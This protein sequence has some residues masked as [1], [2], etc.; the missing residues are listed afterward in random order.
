MVDYVTLKQSMTEALDQAFSILEV[1]GEEMRDAFDNT[2]ENLQSSSIGE[3]REQAADELDQLSKPDVPKLVEDMPVSWREQ[4]MTARQQAKLSR[5]DR[6]DRSVNILENM[7]DALAARLEELD[8][9]E[10]DGI[11][12]Q[13][14]EIAAFKDELD[15]LVSG[16]CA[17]EFPGRG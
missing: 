4:S 10:G 14:E 16:A 2:P 5:S 8:K 15:D 9:Q 17:V 12:E 7:V 3:A 11:E 13:K 1:L 6:R